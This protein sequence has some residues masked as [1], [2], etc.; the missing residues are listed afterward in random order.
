MAS[1]LESVIKTPETV[2]EVDVHGTFDGQP[3]KAHKLKRDRLKAG[4][5]SMF[6]PVLDFLSKRARLDLATDASP[7]PPAPP[8]M[9]PP[10]PPAGQNAL[11]SLSFPGENQHLRPSQEP[12]KEANGKPTTISMGSRTMTAP[13]T[14]IH[15]TASLTDA[16]R[17]TTMTGAGRNMRPSRTTINHLV[18]TG[19]VSMCHPEGR[20]GMP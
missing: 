13:T 2:T 11:C 16:P 12:T 3:V 5:A 6:P 9:P 20:Q 17:L 19:Q 15:G 7:L 18:R 14:A 10:P 8:P 1:T 4:R